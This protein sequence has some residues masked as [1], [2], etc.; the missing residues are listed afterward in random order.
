MKD[1][2]V[3]HRK[4]RTLRFLAKTAVV[5]AAAGPVAALLLQTPGSSPPS[6]TVTNPDNNPVIKSVD[7]VPIFLEDGSTAFPSDLQ[8]QII[9]F[10]IDYLDPNSLDSPFQ[11]ASQYGVDTKHAKINGVSLQDARTEEIKKEIKK[12]VIK[13]LIKS[14]L[15]G[16]PTKFSSDD[17]KSGRYDQTMSDAIEEK[18]AKGEFPPNK[19]LIFFFPKGVPTALLD[20]YHFY[21]FKS[22]VPYTVIQYPGDTIDSLKSGGLEFGSNIDR[23]TFALSAEVDEMLADPYANGPKDKPAW[24]DG[25]TRYYEINDLCQNDLIKLSTGQVVQGTWSNKEWLQSRNK[26]GT[27]CSPNP[28]HVP[29]N[30]PPDL[31]MTDTGLVKLIG[32]E[33]AAVAVRETFVAF[34]NRCSKVKKQENSGK[35]GCER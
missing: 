22:S 32:L 13:K 1:G 27:G 10:L 31:A 15:T 9:K 33:F 24:Q 35:P 18:I 2:S 3:D 20:A 6:V 11:V 34:H 12:E 25:N 5:T 19:Q 4:R 7:L 14:D 30:L 26:S 29:P 28:N 16:I 21:T 23:C 8:E 17:V